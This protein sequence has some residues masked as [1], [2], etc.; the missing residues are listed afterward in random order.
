VAEGDGLLN[1]YTGSNPYPGFESP[2][3]RYAEPVLDGLCAF[4]GLLGCGDLQWIGEAGRQVA[5]DSE[6]TGAVGGAGN[7]GI[8]SVQK[9]ML[10]KSMSNVTCP[11]IVPE[12]STFVGGT[13]GE[14]LSRRATPWRLENRTASGNTPTRL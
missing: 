12:T 5:V 14:T 1:R 11:F 4:V 2:S 9:P 10:S 8:V 13:K 7:G 3:L 6:D